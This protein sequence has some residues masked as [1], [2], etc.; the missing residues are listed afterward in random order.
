MDERNGYTIT[1]ELLADPKSRPTALICGSILLADGAYRAI[2]DAGL[3]VGR[4]ISVVAHDDV[5]AEQPADRFRPQLTVTDA[6]LFETGIRLA[7]FLVKMAKGEA[8]EVLQETLPVRV[9]YRA[10][11]QAPANRARPALD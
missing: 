6:P 4:D 10:S 11:A 2:A 3:Q 9:I 1:R 7:Q 8:P 5:S